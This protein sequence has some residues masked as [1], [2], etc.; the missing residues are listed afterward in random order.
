M[1]DLAFGAHQLTVAGQAV[2]ARPRLHT[3][4][5]PHAW[6]ESAYEESGA[7]SRARYP[8]FHL[9]VLESVF[10]VSCGFFPRRG[11]GC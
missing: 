3:E 8:S 1:G 6:T 5:C 4:T 9:C 10:M 7:W 2:P 11:S